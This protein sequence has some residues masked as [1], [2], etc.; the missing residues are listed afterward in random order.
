MS[1]DAKLALALKEI[2]EYCRTLHHSLK[3]DVDYFTH[4][5]FAALEVSNKKKSQLIVQLSSVIY[6]LSKIY[7]SG[8]KEAITQLPSSHEIKQLLVQLNDEVVQCNHYIA[9]NS[10]VVLTNLNMLKEIW[11]KL[12]ALKS[13]NRIY[14]KSGN[15]ITE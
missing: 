12:M 10:G 4:D 6:E 11:D 3:D 1:D 15:V 9:S 7:P 8:L 13:E 14:D 2:I 5:N